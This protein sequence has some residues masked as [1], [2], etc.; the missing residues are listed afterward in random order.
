MS[1]QEQPPPQNPAMIFGPFDSGAGIVYADPFRVRR[2]ISQ[3]AGSA[4][5]INANIALWKAPEPQLGEEKKPW[6]ASP[7]ASNA[8]ETF[9]RAMVQAFELTPWDRATAKGLREDGV[10]V[11]WNAWCAFETQKKTSGSGSQTTS[12]ST[13]NGPAASVPPSPPIP[14]WVRP[15]T[16]GSPSTS[17][18]SG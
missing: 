8:F 18:A 10:M 9:I 13:A 15:S 7:E 3:Y 11:I 16:S 6:V 1:P 2:R 4:R 17:P 5:E 12:P 14:P